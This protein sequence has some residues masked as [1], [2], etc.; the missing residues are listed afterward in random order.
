M[1]A[2]FRSIAPFLLVGFLVTATGW[3]AAWAQDGDASGDVEITEDAEVEEK[4]AE[5]AQP[6]KSGK[7]PKPELT[8]RDPFRNP[9]L[10]GEVDG[11]SIRRD[12]GRARV[13]AKRSEDGE[14]IV[15]EDGEEIIY[16]DE[17]EEEIEAPS[18]TISGIVSSGGGNRAILSSPDQTYIVSVG[19]KLSSFRV[20]AISA[21]SVTFTYKDRDFKVEMEDEFGLE[22]K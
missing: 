6:K 3:S 4:P 5:V 20:S 21:K 19:D 11:G 16:E 18:V 12:G 15:G 22:T 8:D 17:E 7:M 14:P 13:L 9:V 10:S 1:R 2:L